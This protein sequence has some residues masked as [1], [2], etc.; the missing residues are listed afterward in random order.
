MQRLTDIAAA[1]KTVVIATHNHG[2][3]ERFPGRA[4]RCQDKK[5]SPID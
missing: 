2:F 1:G 3:L 4:L 5:L